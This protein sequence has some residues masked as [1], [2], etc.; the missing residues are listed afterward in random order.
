MI[1][2]ANFTSNVPKESQKERT[3]KRTLVVLLAAAGY[4]CLSGSVVGQ[5]G[6]NLFSKPNI[7]DIFKPVVGSGA[8]Y[9]MQPTDQKRAPSLIEMTIVG[10][11]LTP[12]GEGY[13]ME[14]G[15]TA[16]KD[17]GALMYSK[18]LVTKDF[19]FTKIVFQQPGQPAMEMPVNPNDMGKNHMKEEMA[20]WHQVGSETITVP[21]GTFSCMH[22]KKDDGAEDVWT[23]DKVTPMAMVKEVGKNDTMVLTKI[24]TGATDHITGPVTKFDPQAFAQQMQQQRQKP[25]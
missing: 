21:A 9:E 18:M 2:H 19:Q 24:I 23:S 3:M 4:L 22:W 25:Q 16:S 7:A 14:V 6:M 20:K 8:V 11:E 12:T 5:M 15:H 1:V 13:W 10:K 17:G